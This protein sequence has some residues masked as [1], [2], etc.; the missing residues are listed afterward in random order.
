MSSFIV[1]SPARA[2]STSLRETL[3]SLD[4]VVCH[5]EIFA[6]AR[7]LGISKKVDVKDVT[8]KARKLE[9][10][11]FYNNLIL[12][13]G[14]DFCGVKV[15]YHQ[16]LAP[17]NCYYVNR[18]LSEN[19]KVVFLWRRNLLKRLQSELLLRVSVGNYSLDD[20]QNVSEADVIADCF[21]QMEM[22]AWITKMLRL[23]GLKDIFFIDFEDMI[24][25]EYTLNDLLFFIGINANATPV[26]VKKDARSKRASKNLPA[27]S[28]SS[29]VFSSG[30]VQR[31]RDVSLHDAISYFNSF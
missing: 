13:S 20:Y 18:L 6:P 5:G 24:D 26:K 28:E 11:T 27:R 14:F 1:L 2:G 10:V 4:G 31:F 15:L 25:P 21:Y 19:P 16:L 23:H 30:V 29:P 7:V 22:A 9:K 17:V 12:P 8:Q 3:D